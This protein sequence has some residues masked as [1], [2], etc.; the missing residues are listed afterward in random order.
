MKIR[1]LRLENKKTQQ[2][3]ADFLSIPQQRYY[4]YEAEKTQP[5]IDLL[6][7]I[8][9]YFNVSLDYLLENE[10]TTKNIVYLDN[11]PQEQKDYISYAKEKTISIADIELQKLIDN[12]NEFEKHELIGTIRQMLKTKERLNNINKGELL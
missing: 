11:L 8:A 3:L 10:Q 4:N 2:E 7:K 6:I 12:L 1:Q 9:N 5:P